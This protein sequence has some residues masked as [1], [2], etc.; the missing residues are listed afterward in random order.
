MS[1]GPSSVGYT[2]GC[3]GSDH[4]ERVVQCMSE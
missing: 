1:P 3:L 2:S 4:N